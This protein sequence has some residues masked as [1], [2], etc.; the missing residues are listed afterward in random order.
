L[1]YNIHRGEN[2]QRG[3]EDF[4]T[5]EIAPKEEQ[6][7]DEMKSIAQLITKACGGTIK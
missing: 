5:K 7:T 1:L 4:M 6:T 2:P 3:I